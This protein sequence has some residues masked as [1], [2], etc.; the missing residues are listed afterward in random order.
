MVNNYK[1]KDNGFTLVEL[2]VSIAL[3]L[4]LFISF[5]TFF[6]NYMTLYYGLQSDA[7]NSIE[8]AE[9]I[10]RIAG[11][12]R[13]LTD[14]TS[15]TPNNLTAYAYFSPND[16]YVSL[17]NYYLNS[18]GNQVLATVTPM[19]SNPPTGTPITSEQKTY[20]IISNYYQ[21]SGQGLFSYYDSSGNELSQPI[22][23]E[24]DITSISINLSEPATHNSNGQS[25]STTVTIRDRMVST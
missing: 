13:G 9:E 3:V 10:E 23:N 17:I 19:T 7:S 5:T 6:V 21:P 14:I 11:V 8:M 18:S 15:A 4:I 20:V 2:L 22:T 12:L 16:T 24:Q 25:L 1:I